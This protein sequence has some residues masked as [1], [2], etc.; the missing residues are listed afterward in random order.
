M[1]AGVLKPAWILAFIRQPA[2]LYR[3]K[4]T[5]LPS[6]GD[7]LGL[8]GGYSFTSI[9]N[10]RRE[11]KACFKPIRPPAHPLQSTTI[12]RITHPYHYVKPRHLQVR[13]KHDAGG[14]VTTVLPVHVGFPNSVRLRRYRQV[15][16]APLC[17]RRVS[18]V[19]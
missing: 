5:A 15:R 2:S 9:V 11:L 7:A 19:R 6:A 13:E 17:E 18:G 4:P 10:Y 8:R 3:Q 12:I 14:L 16:D 1:V